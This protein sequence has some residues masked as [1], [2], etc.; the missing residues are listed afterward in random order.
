VFAMLGLGGGMLYVPIFKWLEFPL[1][2]VAIPMGLLLN[3]LNTLLAF[4]HFARA[5]LVD[6][7]GGMP[8]AIAALVLAPVGAWTVQFVDRDTLVLLFAIAVTVAGVR[9]LQNAGRSEPTALM[10]PFKRFVLGAMVG[11]L[12]GFMGGL[13]G[14]GGGF[15]IAPMLMEMGYRTK[16]AA[17]TTAFIVTFS[18]FSGFLGH[19][20]QGRIDPVL[21]VVTVVAVVAGSQL[22]AW[23]MTAKAHPGW[24]KRLYGVVLLGVAAKLL[25]DI[26]TA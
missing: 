9:S 7:R 20:A 13:L 1:K 2:T 21:A 16:E 19:M 17:A 15:I 23:Y 18:S 12:A 14:L 26:Y 5:G 4:L 6:F 24:L 11:G 25:H 22:G 3:G 8:A 10:A